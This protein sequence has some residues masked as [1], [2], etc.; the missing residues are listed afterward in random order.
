MYVG[1]GFCCIFP[2]CCQ[3]QIPVPWG[4]LDA[5]G[6]KKPGLLHAPTGAGCCR[7]LG[8]KGLCFP[9]AC[10]RASAGVTAQPHPASVMAIQGVSIQGI[11]SGQAG[12]KV[13]RHIYCRLGA[14]SAGSPT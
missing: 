4:G 12:I 9:M 1:I 6:L 14:G 13:E 8:R 7:A 11:C 5:E 3:C 10:G 2:A